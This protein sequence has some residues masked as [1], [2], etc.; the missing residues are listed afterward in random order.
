MIG[1]VSRFLAYV[2]FG[3]AG[4]LFV[5]LI[6]DAVFRHWRLVEEQIHDIEKRLELLNGRFARLHA[7]MIAP[8]LKGDVERTKEFLRMRKSL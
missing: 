3:L 1:E 6:Y 7:F 2:V 5:L 4:V 8:W